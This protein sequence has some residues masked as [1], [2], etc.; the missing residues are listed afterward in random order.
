MK[1]LAFDIGTKR[2]GL[3]VS[4]DA[5]IIARPLF[6]VEVEAG[7]FAKIGQ[8]IQA[9]KPDVAVFG[10][11][12]HLS[13]EEAAEAAQ[14]RE[15]AEGIKNEFNVKIDFEDETGTSLEAERRLKERGED[16]INNKGLVDAEAAAIILEGY[17]ART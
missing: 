10:I 5:G 8:V 2:V 1:Y 14:I 15:F 16:F 4:D 13:G 6:A 3:A 12:R 7:L 11:P 17:L 9:E